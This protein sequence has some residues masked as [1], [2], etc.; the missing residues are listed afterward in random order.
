MT[1]H[2]RSTRETAAA[3]IAELV[4]RQKTDHSLLQDLY[5]S[6]EA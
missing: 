1:I 3:R 5:N 4:H 2:T 6:E